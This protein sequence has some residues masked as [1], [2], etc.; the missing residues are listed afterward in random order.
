MS[1]GFVRGPDLLRSEPEPLGKIEQGCLL[2]ILAFWLAC[3]A[4]FAACAY[5]AARYGFRVGA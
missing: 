3:S 5:S 1:G 4:L 2:F